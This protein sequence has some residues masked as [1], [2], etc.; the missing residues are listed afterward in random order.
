[1]ETDFGFHPASPK[2]AAPAAVQQEGNHQRHLLLGSQRLHLEDVAQGD[3][4][5][6]VGLLLLRPLAKGGCL[7]NDTGLPAQP[8][9]GDTR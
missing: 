9:A 2:A 3:A 6:A 8:R 7:A 5:L 1:M 4:P